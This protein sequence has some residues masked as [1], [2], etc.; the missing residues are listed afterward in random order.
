MSS[1]YIG[2]I[3]WVNLSNR[4]W[5]DRYIDKELSRKYIGGS[6]LGAYFLYKGTSKK[7]DPLGEDNLI[8]FMTGP[9]IGSP[10]PT[11]GRHS[12]ISK[13]PL[14]G[15]LGESDI[16]GSWGSGLKLA[17]YD[18]IVIQGK[19]DE[20]VY[21][22]INEGVPTLKDAEHLWGYD[23]YEVDKMIKDEM[24]PDIQITSIGRAGEQLVPIAG[25]FSDGHHGRAAGRCGLGA[26]M[27]SK[28]LKAIAVRGSQKPHIFK[29]MQ[30]IESIRKI[31]PKVK[32]SD[33]G[34]KGLHEF[35]TARLVTGC[36]V[37]GD[38]PIKNWTLGKWEEGADKIS[39]QRIRDKFFD[40]H[41]Y[42]K[43]CPFGC[44]KTIRISQ[45]QFGPVYG[46]SPE[47]ETLAAL[48]SMCLIDDLEAICRG[49]EICNRTGIDTISAGTVIAFAME[50][51][52]KGLLSTR[53]ADGIDL[54]W[55]EPSSMIKLLH[56]IANREGI[57]ELLGN[58]VRHASE[59]IGKNSQEF[60]IHVKGL[61]LPMH[62]PRAFSSLAVGYATSPI[63]ASHWAASHILEGNL[64][65][66][67]L[68]YYEPL[69]R[70]ENR[71]K[72]IM[73]AKMQN[74]ISMFNALKLCRFIMRISLAQ[75][76][77][78]TNYV[79]GWDMDPGEFLET[80][81]RIFNLKRMYNV[82]C[83]LSRKDDSL[84]PRIL[85]LKRG[86]GGAA[87]NLPHLGMMLGEYYN[88]RDWTE[89][90]VP[91]KD[92]LKSLKLLNDID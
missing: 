87:D 22:M 91:S 1:D 73:V 81:E 38:L 2:K 46:A 8:I 48:G 82:H 56:K 25:I 47:Y 88:F 57:G 4:K 30:L 28:N 76:L 84:P 51:F 66:P 79:T 7:T 21:L 12:I 75:I 68:G 6:G 69:D 15:I 5:E 26:V 78:W 42:C 45:S 53:D 58:G 43:A 83:G 40:G 92:K 89:D 44:G 86:E 77:E 19:S 55:G 65:L 62:D 59:Q 35:G 33:K 64:A 20:P 50:A 17:G 39:G 61:E 31:I 23:T 16:G 60:A 9:F 32:Q 70:F 29:R 18:G 10:A 14:T 52:E 85:T 72:G 71:G 37:L 90:G 63:G 24:S 13:S 80:G 74:Y 36:E 34:L 11:S 41:F 27:G 54:K 49:N 67:E 3:L